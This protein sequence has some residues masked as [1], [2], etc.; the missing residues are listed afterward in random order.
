MV[1]VSQ[2]LVGLLMLVSSVRT[3]A[4]NSVPI[5]GEVVRGIYGVNKKDLPKVA[6]YGFNVVQSYTIQNMQPEQITLWVEGMLHQTTL[7][8]SAPDMRDQSFEKQLENIVA[9]KL[10]RKEVGRRLIMISKFIQRR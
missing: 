4:Q 3:L 1:K 5:N 2:I 10:S 9:S 6:E 8:L 7:K